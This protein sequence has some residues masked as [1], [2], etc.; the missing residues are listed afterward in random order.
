MHLFMEFDVVI[1]KIFNKK[2]VLKHIKQV[3]FENTMFN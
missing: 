2:C 3:G 1:F